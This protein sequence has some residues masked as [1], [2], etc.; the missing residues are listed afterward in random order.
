[1]TDP[2]SSVSQVKSTSSQARRTNGH[3][4][5]LCQPGD[6]NSIT[7]VPARNWTV[8]GQ[9]IHETILFYIF[10]LNIITTKLSFLLLLNCYCCCMSVRVCVAW[11]SCFLFI[12]L[13]ISK[14]TSNLLD[15]KTKTDELYIISSLE[16]WLC[17]KI[18]HIILNFLSTHTWH[19]H[20]LL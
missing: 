6:W 17:V 16:W 3:N 11:P 14:Y 10:G 13:W 1:M 9:M 12:L 18:I 20:I 8:R 15:F 7:I 19:T 4:N 5:E 2:L